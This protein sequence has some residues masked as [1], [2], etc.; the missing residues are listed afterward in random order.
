MGDEDEILVNGPRGAPADVEGALELGHDHA[1]LVAPDGDALDGEPLDVDALAGDLGPGLPVLLL[2]L[3]R[4]VDRGQVAGALEGIHGARREGERGRTPAKV[5]DLVAP[6]VV[7]V[8]RED[9]GGFGGRDG[10]GDS[11]FLAALVEDER[12]RER[13]REGLWEVFC[14]ERV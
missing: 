7:V 13:G 10:D 6:A 1:G 12:E 8:E 11:H 4:P 14:R 9:L 5:G 2:L 3:H